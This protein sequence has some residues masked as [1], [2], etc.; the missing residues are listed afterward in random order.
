[1]KL[2]A[3]AGRPI[4]LS[5]AGFDPSGGAGVLAD[6]KTFES[7]AVYGV[8]VCTAITYQNDTEFAGLEWLNLEQIK[9]QLA[10]LADRFEIGWAKIGIIRDLP[11]LA[12]LIEELQ[13]LWP[14]ICIVW[15]PVGAA[16]AGFTF[17]TSF[18][19]SQ[20]IELLEQLALVTP[21]IPELSL[22]GGAGEPLKVAAGLSKHA[23]ILL[24][25][26]HAEGQMVTD[27]LCVDGA[28]TGFS[29]ARIENARKHGSGCV[30]SAALVAELAKGCSL[31][32]AVTNARE[33]IRRFLR[34]TEAVL[35][36][37][38]AA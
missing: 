15:D 19:R 4:V 9:S 5:V 25:G 33:Y 8:G 24:K 35:G 16:S 30:L 27:L 38:G 7:R 2:S 23:P 11:V 31:Q 20:L 37:H 36:L 32:S 26:G 28:V 17:H 12:E 1:M 13:R 14:S 22:L 3:V 29:S 18:E 21:N 6:C 10:P 34:S